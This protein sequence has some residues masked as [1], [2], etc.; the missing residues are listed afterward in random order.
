MAKIADFAHFER[1]WSLNANFARHPV[2][3]KMLGIQSSFICKSRRGGCSTHSG[4]TQDFPN[5]PQLVHTP[6][7]IFLSEK[8]FVNYD[9]VGI[10][11]FL[12]IWSVAISSTRRT[13]RNCFLWIF[14]HFVLVIHLCIFNIFS[15]AFVPLHYSCLVSYFRQAAKIV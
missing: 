6:L 3:G 11:Q 14:I 15:C 1:L 12:W 10:Y 2:Y 9:H 4:T 5:S 7:L 13:L 8:M